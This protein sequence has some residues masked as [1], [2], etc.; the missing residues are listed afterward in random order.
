MNKFRSSILGGKSAVIVN[1][2]VAEKHGSEAV[3]DD[4][5]S[6]GIPR[7]ASRTANHRDD[8]RHRL[9]GESA[10]IR[11][12]SE[13][14]EVELINLSGGGAMI[15]ADIKPRMWDRVDLILGE[16]A[17]FECAVRW[18]RN[19]RIGLEFAHE[20]KI[21][22]PTAQR[23]AL[24][25]EVIRRSFPDSPVLVGNSDPEPKQI[26]TQALEATRRGDH[27]HPL[28]WKGQIL[29]QHDSHDCRLRNISESG[30]L[31]D[32]HVDLPTDAELLLDLGPSGQFFATVSWS[33]GGQAGLAFKNSFDLGVLAKAR[34]E[35]AQRNWTRPNFLK[36]P[37][38]QASPW[39]PEW[40]RSSLDE[41]REDLEGFMKH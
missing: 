7:D 6:V 24:L 33:R 40:E 8:D 21:D 14:H 25:L 4:L 29:W 28:I 19:D 27:R 12:K 41:L 38:N 5:A 15:R 3:G 17:A 10:S 39:A 16:G 34:P 23:D 18:L 2:V 31:V 30:A 11:Y 9:H 22:C 36:G 35:V 13:I 26:R 20:T 1:P 37:A 32:C